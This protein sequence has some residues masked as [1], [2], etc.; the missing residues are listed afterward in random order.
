[1]QSARLAGP[2]PTMPLVY[3][4]RSADEVAYADEWRT[5]AIEGRGDVLLTVTRPA[6]WR[7]GSTLHRLSVETLTSM[8]RAYTDAWYF[9]CGPPAFVDDVTVALSHA[10]VRAGRIRREGW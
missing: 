7:P 5:W 4:V 9:V 1:M 6:G 2:A 10:G 8:V 3:S